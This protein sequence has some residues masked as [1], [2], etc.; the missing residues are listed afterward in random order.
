M[1][2]AQSTS[3]PPYAAK[4]PL[5][6]A[7]HS[8]YWLQ[9]LSSFLPGK[10][11]PRQQIS[12]VHHPYYWDNPVISTSTMNLNW[13]CIP[14]RWH[15]TLLLLI[16][17]ETTPPSSAAVDKQEC[18]PPICHLVNTVHCHVNQNLLEPLQQQRE[19]SR[20]NRSLRT[21]GRHLPLE[22]WF[23]HS[24]SSQPWAGNVEICK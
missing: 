23:L 3:L 8:S 12:P 16:S 1:H 6:P 14:I 18:P 4:Q 15:W 7:S 20:N 24:H 19:R 9:S 10:N 17:M 21:F 22:F 11:I 2:V 13:G 5:Q